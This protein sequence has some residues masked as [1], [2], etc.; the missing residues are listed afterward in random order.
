MSGFNTI[1]YFLHKNTD[2][3]ANK[4][5]HS[6]DDDRQIEEIN[7]KNRKKQFM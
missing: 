2:A 3:D 5:T 7:K 4:Q 6:L 1:I